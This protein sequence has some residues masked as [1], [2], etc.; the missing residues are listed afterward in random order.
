MMGGECPVQRFIR[1]SRAFHIT[2]GTANIQKV[3]IARHLLGL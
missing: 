3:I 1:D 2:E